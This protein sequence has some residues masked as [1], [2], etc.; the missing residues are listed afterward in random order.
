[1]QPLILAQQVTQGVADFLRTATQRRYWSFDRT[2]FAFLMTTLTLGAATTL[3]TTAL[4][5]W[6]AGEQAELVPVLKLCSAAV[7]GL[8]V[9]TLLFELSIFLHLG[10]KQ[11]GDLKRS[12][13]L[14]ATTLRRPLELR[15]GLFALGGCLLPWWS[16]TLFGSGSLVSGLALAA[17]SLGV[18][19]LS[20]FVERSLY[21][22]AVSAPR[23][24]GTVSR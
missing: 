16:A 2:G 6:F 17:L 21:F 24:P 18:L 9:A 3:F 1:M 12:A 7:P 13:T 8:G 19:V 15:W 4:A 14:L 22:A 5:V 11:Q 10:D 20:A 23:M